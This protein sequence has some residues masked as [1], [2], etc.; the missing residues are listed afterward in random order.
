MKNSEV[1]KTFSIFR[2][3][4]DVDL[5]EFDLQAITMAFKL[6]FIYTD[7]YRFCGLCMG[8]KKCLDTGV[9]IFSTTENILGQYSILSSDFDDFFPK[10]RRR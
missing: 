5:R 6:S 7:L 9:Q 8:V 3:R 10:C 1:Q 2:Q 4:L